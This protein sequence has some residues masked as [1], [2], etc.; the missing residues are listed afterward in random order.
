MDYGVYG[1]CQTF[2]ELKHYI[3]YKFGDTWSVKSNGDIADLGKL[4]PLFVRC[5]GIKCDLRISASGAC[6]ETDDGFRVKYDHDVGTTVETCVIPVDKATRLLTDIADM[7]KD[8]GKEIDDA[9][10]D[11][12]QND[13]IEGDE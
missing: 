5:N 8:Y 13:F 2:D 7:I 9:I 6:F 3:Q 1:K 12:L 11:F 10:V 4:G